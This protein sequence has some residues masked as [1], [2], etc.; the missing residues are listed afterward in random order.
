MSDIRHGSVGLSFYFV[1]TFCLA[2][3]MHCYPQDVTDEE[4]FVGT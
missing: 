4:G 1:T 3:H 2:R